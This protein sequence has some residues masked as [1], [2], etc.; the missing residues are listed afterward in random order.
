MSKE[1]HTITYKVLFLCLLMVNILTIVVVLVSKTNSEVP[2]VSAQTLNSPPASANKLTTPSLNGSVPQVLGANTGINVAWQD[3]NSNVAISGN[4][5]I[6]TNAPV[7]DLDVR[8]R[9]GAS[10]YQNGIT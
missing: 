5:G 8:E 4:L 6:G 7:S 10:Q 3:I 2:S 9:T 1:T